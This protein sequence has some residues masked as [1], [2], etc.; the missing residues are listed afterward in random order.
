MIL[1]YWVKSYVEFSKSDQGSAQYQ[2]CSLSFGHVQDVGLGH[3]TYV[4]FPISIRKKW[5]QFWFLLELKF[6]L[7]VV[8][9]MKILDHVMKVIWIERKIKLI[10]IESGGSE[11]I[12]LVVGYNFH[13]DFYEF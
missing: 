4:L 5:P 3:D 12:N 11:G 9:S 7:L 10:D 8:F 2:Q 6:K 1:C 13:G